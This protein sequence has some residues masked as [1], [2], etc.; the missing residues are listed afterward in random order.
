MKGDEILTVFRRSNVIESQADCYQSWSKG[1]YISQIDVHGLM[2][3]LMQGLTQGLTLDV[4]FGSIAH[5]PAD[6]HLVN[7]VPPAE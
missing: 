1:Q 2:Q 6:Q 4:I 7:R 3:G 5:S